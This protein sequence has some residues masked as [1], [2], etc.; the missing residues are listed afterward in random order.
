MVVL[1]IAEII[2]TLAFALSGYFVGVSYMSLKF[3]YSFMVI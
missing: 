1:E 2:G 3:L